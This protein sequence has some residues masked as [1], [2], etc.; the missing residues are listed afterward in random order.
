MAECVCVCTCVCR[1]GSPATADQTWLTPSPVSLPAFPELSN[2]L[3]CEISSSSW[4]SK[5]NSLNEKSFLLKS[6]LLRSRVIKH[7]S[8]YAVS[9]KI[10]LLLSNAMKSIRSSLASVTR[11]LHSNPEDVSTTSWKFHLM[12]STYFC[13]LQSLL[14]EPEHRPVEKQVF[15]LVRDHCVFRDTSICLSLCGKISYQSVEVTLPGKIPSLI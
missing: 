15:P 5:T 9:R 4:P 2:K 7:H 8:S 10:L 1:C 13:R 12:P 6:F 3:I 14:I 11:V